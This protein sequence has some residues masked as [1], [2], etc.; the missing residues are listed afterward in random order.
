MRNRE[1]IIRNIISHFA[2]LKAEVEYRSKVNLQDINVHAEQFYKIL[3][4][5]ILALNLEN[6]NIVEQNAAVIDLADKTRKIAIQVT[7]NNSKSKKELG[8]IYRP[9]KETLVDFFMIAESQNVYFLKINPMYSSAFSKYA[10][11]I[12]NKT[13]IKI[14]A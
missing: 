1:I 2:V 3:L 9:L 11:I 7:S 13:F 12:G 4:N 14:E 8:M 5:D 10:A 6:I